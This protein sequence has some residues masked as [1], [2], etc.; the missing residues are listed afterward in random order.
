MIELDFNVETI[1][2]ARHAVTPTLLFRL[3][4]VNC[5]PS[6]PVEHVALQAQIRIEAAH[7]D[8]RAGERERL[9]EL[10]GGP[11][12][13]DRTLRGLLWTN[14]SA[15][16]P[17]FVEACEIDL[18]VPCSCDFNIAATKYFD[19][20][21][22][23]EAPLLLLFSGTVFCRNRDGDLQIAQVPHHKEA[24]FRLP[25]HTW[26]AMMQYYY[27]DTTW[28]RVGRDLFDELQRFKRRTGAT[29]IDAALQR[30]LATSLEG[31]SP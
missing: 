10:F 26:Q 3:R 28:L 12:D 27:P 17:G 24:G 4:I 22:D 6:V 1:A 15:A 7:R 31:A 30:L 20:I 13:W 9:S 19:G 16:V 18:P 2:V 5:T 23:G 8:Y 21:E 29:S 25:V 11:A 14:A